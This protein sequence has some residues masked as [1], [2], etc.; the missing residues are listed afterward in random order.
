MSIVCVFKKCSHRLCVHHWSN[1]NLCMRTF[2]KNFINSNECKRRVKTS[3]W[4]L[5]NEYSKKR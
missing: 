4:R 5:Q 3:E 1:R 2:F